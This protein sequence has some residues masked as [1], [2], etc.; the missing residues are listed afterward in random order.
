MIFEAFAEAKKKLRAIEEALKRDNGEEEP[1]SH[2]AFIGMTVPLSREPKC[3]RE[4]FCS[5]YASIFML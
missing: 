1:L 2:T 3:S 5:F 4:C